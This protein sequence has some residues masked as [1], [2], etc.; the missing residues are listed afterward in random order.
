MLALAGVASAAEPTTRPEYVEAL[1]A[2]CAP[3]AEAT[4]R[5]VK[6]VRGDVAAERFGP[7]AR[8]F[9]AAE[10][11]F[12]STVGKIGAVPRPAADRPSSASGSAT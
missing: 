9:A 7:A 12:A 5:A 11:I 6:G 2:I 8:K 1:E 3:R 4:E 10:H